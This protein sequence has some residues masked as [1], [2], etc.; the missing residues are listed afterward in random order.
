MAATIEDV[1]RYCNEYERKTG[2]ILHYGEAVVMIEREERAAREALTQLKQE[3]K[4]KA[5]TSK[6]KKKRKG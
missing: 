4:K 6:G 5:S 1:V 3:A 2:K